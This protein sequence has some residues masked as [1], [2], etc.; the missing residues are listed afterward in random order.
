VDKDNHRFVDQLLVPPGKEEYVYEVF[1]ENSKLSPYQEASLSQEK[2]LEELGKLY[3][4]L[5]YDG[6]PTVDLP[7]S[8]P[9]LNM[10][11]DQA[12][13]HRRSRRDF[14]PSIITLDEVATLLIYAYGVR[15]RNTDFPRSFRFVPSG[16]GLFPLE[17]YLYTTCLKGQAPGIY[18]YNPLNNHLR[19]IKEGHYTPTLAESTVQPEVIQHACAVIFLTGIFQRSIFKYG[20]RGYRFILMESGHVAQNINL[21]AGALG[22]GCVNIGGFFDRKVDSFLGLDGVTH[23]TL[24]LIALGRSSTNNKVLLR[25]SEGI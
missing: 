1:H 6:Y 15:Q 4:C 24:Y 25:E 3:E 23:S 10:P 9:P 16:G 21:V 14:I 11:L 19:L 8:L 2:I 12:I 7:A 18:H 13:T 5:P 22:M 20:E 17:L